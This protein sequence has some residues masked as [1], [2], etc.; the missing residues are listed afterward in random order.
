M[1]PEVAWRG[2]WERMW[3]SAGSEKSREE[4]SVKEAGAWEQE[5]ENITYSQA[6]I[7]QPGKPWPGVNVITVHTAHRSPL[8]APLHLRKQMSRLFT[9]WAPPP[10]AHLFPHT[11]KH[12]TSSLWALKYIH[13]MTSSDP[14]MKL[15][16]RKQNRRLWLVTHL[17]RSSALPASV[18]GYWI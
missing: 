10:R 1:L 13:P 11:H 9:N 5:R 2:R 6:L 7:I 4:R 18:S 17:Q 12:D 8:H 15:R 16:N 3:Q 14:W